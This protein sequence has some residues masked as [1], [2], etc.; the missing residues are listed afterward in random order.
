MIEPRIT[1]A[2]L[3]YCNGDAQY[4]DEP[5]FA[6]GYI[7]RESQWISVND[8]LPEIGFYLAWVVDATNKF[9]GYL[10]ILDYGPFEFWDDVYA[11]TPHPDADED[12]VIHKFGWN[13]SRASEGVYDYL[14]FD[15]NEKVSHWMGLPNR[16]TQIK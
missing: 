14:V 12:G 15:M 6:A 2:F 11:Q 16:P 10:D 4:F 1:E 3:V 13:Y 9:G 7:A 5:S 8:K